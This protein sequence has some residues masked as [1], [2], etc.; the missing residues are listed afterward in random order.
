MNG[1]MKL[2]WL[3]SIIVMLPLATSFA[4]G[5]AIPDVHSG[6]EFSEQGELVYVDREGNRLNLYSEWDGYTLDKLRSQPVGTENGV[7]FDFQQPLLEGKLYYGFIPEPGE[8]K[9]AYPIFFNRTAEIES[10]VAEIDIKGRMAGKYDF[11]DW[12][13]TGLIRLGYRVVDGNGQLIYDGKIRL[14]GAGPFVVDTSIT[15]G[16]LIN[17]VTHESAVIS[18]ETNVPIAA[19]VLA[20]EREFSEVRSSKHH[21]IKLTRLE[22]DRDYEYTVVYGPYREAYS[23]R[24]APAPGSRTQFTFAYASD[25]RGNTGGGER[26]LWGVNAYILKK[27]AVLCSHMDVRFFQFTGD[28]IDGYSIDIGDIELQYANW[29]RTIE[30]FACYFPFIAGFGNHEALI[31][32]FRDDERGASIDKFPYATHSAE[33]IFARNFVNPANGPVSEDGSVYDPNPDRMDFPPYEET[34]FYYTYDNVAIISLNSNYWYAPSIVRSPHIGGNLH[35]YI[36]DKQ[37]EWLESTLAS[38][39]QDVNIDHVFITL[40]TP[41]LPNGGHVR[42]DMWYNGNN[43]PRPWIAG[44][45]VEKGI[46]ERRDQLLDLLMN[47]SSKVKATL[48]GDEHN[49]SLLRVSEKLNLYPDDWDGPR[50]SKFRPFWHINNGA[51]GAPYYGREETPWSE[52][53]QVFSTQNA[54]VFFHVDGELVRVEVINPDTMEQIDG[55]ML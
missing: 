30:P 19:A 46:I 21:E 33:V 31:H 42:D 54:V 51:A 25:G 8:V 38:L 43:E 1:P 47:H 2:L 26:D 37:M 23:F 53:V 45:P 49:Y 18:F 29:K 13:K 5:Q 9:H 36:M 3:I 44:K 55:F 11:V 35:G 24:T 20:D 14:R 39:E 4:Q 50:L 17:L 7:R 48:T 16:P 6:L 40:H 52:H 32:Y 41:I 28:L 34:A 15:E 12:Q 10:G 22:P 27:I